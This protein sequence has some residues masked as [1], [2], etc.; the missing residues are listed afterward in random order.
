M[1]PRFLLDSARA[2]DVKVNVAVPKLFS[3]LIVSVVAVAVILVLPPL[4]LG[5]RLPRER[6]VRSFL[7]VFSGNRRGLHPDRSGADPEVRAVSRASD[8]CVDGGD[9][10]DAGFERPREVFSAGS[11]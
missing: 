5:T 7:L 1:L 8:L 9:F 10:L 6:S 11:W 4:V 3:A 2:A